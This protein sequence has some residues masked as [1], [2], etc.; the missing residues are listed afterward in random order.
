MVTM[1][2]NIIPA[3]A[4]HCLKSVIATGSVTGTELK[5]FATIICNYR[6]EIVPSQVWDVFVVHVIS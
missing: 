6:S 1:T 4:R 2:P 5:C 3:N